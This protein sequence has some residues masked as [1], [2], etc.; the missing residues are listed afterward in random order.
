MKA[1][2][3]ISYQ[4]NVGDIPEMA[5]QLLRIWQGHAVVIRDIPPG[6]SARPL[7]DDLSS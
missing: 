7:E 1:Q 3:I 5:T 4:P 6:R 2:E